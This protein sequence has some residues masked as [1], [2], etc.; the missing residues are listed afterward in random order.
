MTLV[1][2]KGKKGVISPTNWQA[3]P[4]NPLQSRVMETCFVIQPFD[5]GK[6]DKRFE[7]VFKPAIL[8]CGLEPYRVDQD[9]RVQIPIQAIEEGIQRACICLADITTDNPNV[10]YELGYALATGK[11]VILICSTER[12]GKKFP[13]DIQHRT[14]TE[15]RVEAPKDFDKLR[16]TITARIK[17]SVHNEE[18]RFG[19]NPLNDEMCL[20]TLSKYWSQGFLMADRTHVDMIKDN[21][22]EVMCQ[23]KHIDSRPPHLAVALVSLLIDLNNDLMSRHDKDRVAK[24]VVRRKN[25][26]QR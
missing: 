23:A 26:K 11:D 22:L 6:F 13:F 19:R 14:I 9:M 17:A 8:A 1:A 24:D 15:Y 21:F 2:E 16:A 4:L 18:D 3:A 20:E 5:S 7:Q 12:E 10:W 25:K